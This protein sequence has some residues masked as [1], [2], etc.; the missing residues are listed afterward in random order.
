MAIIR[1]TKAQEVELSA[2]REQIWQML[3]AKLAEERRSLDTMTLDIG[4]FSEKVKRALFIA[5]MSDGEL[6][7]GIKNIF[8][9][10]EI[11]VYVGGVDNSLLVIEMGPRLVAA[12][13]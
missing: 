2:F 13:Q 1:V 4:T 6:Y 9:N 8:K 10:L 3:V 11:N 5:E 7:E 12:K